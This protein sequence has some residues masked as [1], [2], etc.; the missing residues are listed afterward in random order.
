MLTSRNTWV[1]TRQPVTSSLDYKIC[2]QITNLA[3]AICLCDDCNS[4]TLFFNFLFCSL[5]SLNLP[6]NFLH[7]LTLSD[8]ITL[9]ICLPNMVSPFFM[10]FDY[11]LKSFIDTV[12]FSHE[13]CTN[14]STN[15]LTYLSA[16][17]SSSSW[18]QYVLHG[19]S[20]GFHIPW[21]S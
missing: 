15:I 3:L 17:L 4:L 9:C 10:T 5:V 1:G 2:I 6:V 7:V 14:M 16:S 13:Q 11:Y 8:V 21:R 20:D 18:H 19:K 12:S